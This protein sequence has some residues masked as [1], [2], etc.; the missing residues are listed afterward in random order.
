MST[1]IDMLSAW[2]RLTGDPLPEA[3][4]RLRSLAEADLLPTWHRPFTYIHLANA[5]LGFVAAMTHK[6][7]A[8][9]VR[10]FGEFRC[11]RA[12]RHGEHEMPFFGKSLRDALE[13]AFHPPFWIRDLEVNVTVEWVRLTV[14]PRPD[15]FGWASAETQRTSPLAPGGSVYWFSDPS[16]L[17]L[18]ATVHPVEVSRTIQRPLIDRLLANLMHHPLPGIEDATPLHK[19]TASI[20]N[21]ATPSRRKALPCSH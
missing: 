16:A 21:P 7:A 10:R 8:A 9:T 15:K 11:T 20:G 2:V 13:A 18:P 14:E 6:D 19:E 4:Q 12:S 1:R 5:M 3:R 17:P